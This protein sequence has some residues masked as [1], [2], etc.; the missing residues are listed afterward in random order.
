MQEKLVIYLHSNDLEH[1]SW[2]MVS[3]DG[4]VHDVVERG[5]ADKLAALTLNKE[6]I[7]IVPAEDVLL[8]TTRL[9]HMNR[10]RL[11]QALPYAIEEQLIEDVENLHFAISDYVPEQV[12]AVA[13]VA[14]TK[15]EQ[16]LLLLKAWQV[17]T[18]VLL[19]LTFALPFSQENW[20]IFIHENVIVRTG[21]LLGFACELDQFATWLP[22]AIEG[23]AQKPK[24]IMLRRYGANQV[25]STI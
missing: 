4:Q 22:M 14:K 1:P 20:Q 9:P 15:M 19:P 2:A 7:V 10:S 5:E 17:Q 25:T 8:T 23:A 3:A 16:W 21:A 12:L 18:D 11:L 13:V 6:I 24:E